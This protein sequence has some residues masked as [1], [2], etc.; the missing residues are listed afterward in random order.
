LLLPADPPHPVVI[1][2]IEK[3][4]PL[5]RAIVHVTYGTSNLKKLRRELLDLIIDDP[6]EMQIA[7]LRKPTRFDLN[8][9]LNKL[10][11][12]WTWEFF[13]YSQPVGRLDINCIRRMNNRLRWRGFWQ[14]QPAKIE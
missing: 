2:E 12:L 8:D 6:N 5:G 11:I 10:P 1:R 7:G 3:N 9:N 14:V 13:P 4:E